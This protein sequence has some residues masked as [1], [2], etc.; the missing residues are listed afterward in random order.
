MG[1]D[2]AIVLHAHLPY[3]RHPEHERSLEERWLFEAILE[4]YLPLLEVFDGLLADGVPFRLTMSLTP[5][6][7]A[8]LKDD[9]LKQRFTSY[10][11]RLEA[12]A[13]AEMKRLFGDAQLAPVATFYR[14]RCLRMHALW[15]RI[16]G[17]LV[18]AFRE[19]WERGH[20][21]LLACSATHAYLPGLMQ[22]PDAI[23]AQL[24]IG[25][26]AF[27]SYVGRAAQGMW[28]PECAYHPSFDQALWDAGVK[29]TIVD[30]HALREA[31]PKPALGAYAPVISPSG[32]AFFG[33]DAASSEQV[34]SREAGYPGDVYYRDFYRDIGFDLPESELRGEVGPFDTRVMTGLKYHRITGQGDDKLA[35]QP[36]IASAR[37]RA[38]GRDFVA[39][40][41]E[42]A[43]A[44]KAPI[45]V[46]PYDAELFGHWWFEGPQFLGAVFRE[47]HARTDLTGTLATVTLSEHLQKSPICIRATPQ[48][49]SW[50]EG[51][52]GEVW[53]GSKSGKLWRHVHHAT[54]YISWLTERHREA[55]GLR[56]ALLDQAIRELLLLQSSDWAFILHTGTSTGY[57]EA[58][59][60]AHTH[61]LRHLGYLLEQPGEAPE[62]IRFLKDLEE[63]DRF[64]SHFHGPQLRAMF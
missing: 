37:A 32:V 12:L 34:W 58:R 22:T 42:Q 26:A 2:L 52:Y 56:G 62:G 3:V 23:R 50:G 54:S 30:G 38:H 6:L 33:R 39:R 55:T 35:Y 31:N 46:A 47:L 45:L 17:D 25:M 57:A 13:E 27:A 28:L 43:R 1:T 49:S 48:A 59:V 4:C 15:D 21:E 29:Y 41:L 24:A 8:M 44:T 10:L 61:R 36:A 53:V 11:L 9:L 7:L 60:R 51:G 18:G 14:D 16:Q 63:R 64:L 19:H 20:L 40:R 5:P